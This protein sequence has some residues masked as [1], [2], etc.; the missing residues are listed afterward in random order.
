MGAGTG[1]AELSS[2]G[3]QEWGE[4]GGES[5]SPGPRLVMEALAPGRAKLGSGGQRNIP[6]AGKRNGSRKSRDRQRGQTVT[7]MSLLRD[8]L[9]PGR[10]PRS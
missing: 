7:R 6:G 2:L 10:E 9:M 1:T 4:G 5:L 8:L 3:D